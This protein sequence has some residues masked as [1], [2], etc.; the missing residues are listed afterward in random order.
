MGILSDIIFGG[1]AAAASAGA[2]LSGGAMSAP[3]VAVDA[4][5]AKNIAQDATRQAPPQQAPPPQPVAPP[6]TGG[7]AM[8][9]PGLI[10]P[11]VVS[12]ASLKAYAR[13]ADR[14]LR[15][16]LRQLGER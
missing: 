13:P 15:D 8:Q 2:V 4:N 14:S 10:G 7:A 11:P 3:A 5:A 12:D 16:F 9:S 1:E 6:P